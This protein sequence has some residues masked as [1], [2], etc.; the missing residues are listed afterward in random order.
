VSRRLTAPAVAALITAAWTPPAAALEPPPPE[1]TPFA[2]A[3]GVEMGALGSTRGDRADLSG[4][5]ALTLELDWVEG[6]WGVSFGLGAPLPAPI[7]GTGVHVPLSVRYFPSGQG[8]GLFVQA[9]VRGM[10]TLATACVS[11]GGCPEPEPGELPTTLGGLGGLGLGWQGAFGHGFG[12]RAHVTYHAGY[13]RGGTLHG[14]G[15]AALTGFYQGA[16][17]GFAL[18]AGLQ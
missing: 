11:G 15:T 6:H 5:N 16:S 17:L 18:R 2:F 14:E 8:D 12:W 4:T 10:A 7:A 9:G 13:L 3:A 1:L